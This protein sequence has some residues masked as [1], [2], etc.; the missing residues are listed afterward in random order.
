[1]HGN[2]ALS[3]TLVGL[4]SIG[5]VACASVEV[6]GNLSDSP[7]ADGTSAA[8]TQKAQQFTSNVSAAI[9]NVILELNVGAANGEQVALNVIMYADA[10]SGPTGAGTTIGTVT[11][12][13][14][15]GLQQITMNLTDSSYLL[16]SGNQYEL[17]LDTTG[18]PTS[19]GVDSVGFE[20]T[21]T[22]TSGMGN[23]YTYNGAW[24]QTAPNNQYMFEIDAVPEPISHS[25]AIFGAIFLMNWVL[26]SF[27][28]RN[29]SLIRRL[30]WRRNS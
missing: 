13:A 3:L 6:I 11:T 7:S 19:A 18:S 1:M 10:G 21:T 23:K 4:L 25:L 20:A 16:T 22:L 2:L 27:V 12:S 14:S 24:T 26:R 15:L 29:H 30:L 8:N 9:N 28:P 17:A 5:S